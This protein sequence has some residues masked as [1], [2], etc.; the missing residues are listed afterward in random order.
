MLRPRISWAAALAVAFGTATYTVAEDGIPKPE[1]LFQSLDKDGD[2]KLTTDEI[3]EGQRKFF[4]RSVRVG[5]KDGDGVLT[6]EEF[7]AANREPVNP[8]VPLNPVGGPSPR[9]G[10]DAKQ[11][12][13]MLDANKDGK[14]TL[15]ELPA[16]IRDRMKPLFERVGQ[17][18][19][20]LQ[21][22]SQIG[23]RGQ[24][25]RESRFQPGQI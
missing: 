2:G 7:V 1:D 16:P 10:M 17:D 13:E 23:G 14:L 15:E 3:P 11:R 8:S 19:I 6:K 25:T 22:F 4:D 12:F 18:D 20:N 21:K 5:D 9:D 24:G